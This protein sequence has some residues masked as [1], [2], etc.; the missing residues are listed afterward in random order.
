MNQQTIFRV[1]AWTSIIAIAIVTDGP[2]GLRPVTPL[3]PGAERFAALAVV[4]L[5]FA[6]AYPARRLLVLGALA[7]AVGA[8]ELGQFLAV[9][10]HPGL[11][12]A[13]AKV[14]GAMTGLAAG[15]AFDIV[16]HNR[17]RTP[18]SSRGQQ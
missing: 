16:M 5:L 4:G 6:L 7:I 17:G 8:L 11:H 9:G 12:D 10:R 18:S 13:G 14:L 15:H 1:L 3:S 2:I